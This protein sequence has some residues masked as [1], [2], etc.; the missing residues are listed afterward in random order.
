VPVDGGWRVY[1]SG[2][3]IAFRLIHERLFGLCRRRATL[4]IDPVL[5]RRL[6][7]LALDVTLAG[8]PVRITYHVGAQGF[9]PSRIAL[10]GGDLDSSASRTRT[11]SAARWWRRR[12]SCHDFGS[13]DLG[14]HLG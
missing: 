14:I 2:A 8:R 7:G 11:G 12:T 1:S 10:N 13:D 3:G 6:D 4:T 9:G 5:P